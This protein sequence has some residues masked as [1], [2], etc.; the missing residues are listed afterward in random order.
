[1]NAI[2]ILALAVCY[3]IPVVAQ[4]DKVVEDHRFIIE[5]K[6]EHKIDPLMIAILKIYESKKKQIIYAASE[7][8]GMILKS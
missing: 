6:G 4:I 3:D 5:Y 1:M 2:E 7:L 8:L